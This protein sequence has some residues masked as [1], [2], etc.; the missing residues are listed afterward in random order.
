MGRQAAATLIDGHVRSEGRQ[1]Q[2][3]VECT[4]V[5]RES[6]GPPARRA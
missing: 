4:L 3:K 5:D 6:V 1:P 2:I